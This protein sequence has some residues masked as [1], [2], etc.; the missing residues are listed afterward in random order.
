MRVRVGTSGFSY[1][2]WKGSFYPEDLPESKML[3]WYAAR[4]DAVEINSSFYRMPRASVL[5]GWAEEVPRGFSF[6][7][8]AQ[9]ALS[10]WRR[11]DVLESA[12]AAFFEAARALGGARGPIFVQM[13]PYQKK[14]LE[15]LRRFLDVV[16]R[17]VKVALEAAGDTWH[18]DDVYRAL[19]ARDVALVAV[20][21]AEEPAPLVATARW[22]YVR[23]RRGRYGKKAL[24]TWSERILAQ[25]WSEAWVFLKHDDEATGPRLARSLVGALAAEGRA[26]VHGAS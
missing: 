16:P 21:D 13:A 7:L 8:K 9:M 19:R 5:E 11:A 23:L 24:A 18:D 20:D 22:G 6:V 15:L 4:F 10:H 14:D 17:G 3:R 26:V 1:K 12:A 25:P 2:E